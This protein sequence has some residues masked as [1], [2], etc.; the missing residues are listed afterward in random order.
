M[1]VRARPCYAS[2]C[3]NPP[4]LTEVCSLAHHETSLTQTHNTTLATPLATRRTLSELIQRFARR[5][6][7][8]DLRKVDAMATPANRPFLRQSAAL[9]RHGAGMPYNC[10]RIPCAC[11]CVCVCVCVYY[12]DHNG[13]S[14]S[15]YLLCDVIRELN[16]LHRQPILYIFN[17]QIF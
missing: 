11:V 13:A 2:M 16:F 12:C 9:E 1:C 17:I 8:V 4:P 5:R 6:A 3:V 7:H 15:L 14:I 10:M